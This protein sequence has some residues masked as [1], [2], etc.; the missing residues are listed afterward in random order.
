MESSEDKPKKQVIT[1]EPEPKPGHQI[2]SRPDKESKEKILPPKR[3]DD[4]REVLHG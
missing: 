4:G 2:D 1:D 3:D